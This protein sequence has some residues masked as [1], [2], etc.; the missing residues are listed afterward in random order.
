MVQVR[1]SRESKQFW[2]LSIHLS[3]EPFWT[4]LF[5]P[6]L[7]KGDGDLQQKDERGEHVDLKQEDHGSIRVQLVEK[8]DLQWPNSARVDSSYRHLR[9]R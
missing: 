5:S 6:Q 1:E 7:H 9:S 4:R 2:F 8:A 3:A